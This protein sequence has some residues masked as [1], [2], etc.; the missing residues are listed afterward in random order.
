MFSPPWS[1]TPQVQIIDRIPYRVYPVRPRHLREV[2]TLGRRWGARPNVIQGEQEVSF[3]GLLRGARR[4]AHDLATHGVRQGDR[5]LLL[6]WNS[7]DWVVN[8]W[9]CHLLGAVPALANAWWS[10]AEIG[11]AIELLQPTIVLADEPG[12]R[13]LPGGVPLAPWPVDSGGEA[14]DLLSPTAGHE[15]DPAVIIFTSGTSGQPKAVELSHRALLANL[16][17]LLR[18]SHRLP[19]EV[20]DTSGEVALHTG[21]LFHVGGP[22]MLLRSVVV[23]NTFVLPAGRFEPANVLELIE[24]HRIT[25]WSAVP[26]MVTRLLDH[27]DMAH[28]DLSSLTSV[29]I[30]GAPVH[31][32]LLQRIGAELPGVRAGVPTGYGLTENGGQATA[33]SGRD[34]LQH[35]G[36][37]GRP[38]PCAE[39]SFQAREG[40]PDAEILLRAPTQMTRYIG[41]EES[42]IDANGWLHTGD[43]GH[44]DEDGRL[45][46]TGRAKDLIIRGGENIAPAAVERALYLIRGV[47]EAAVIGIPHPDLGEEVCAFVVT[48]E[49]GP[50]IE[51]IENALRSNLASFAVPTVWHVKHEPLPTNQTGKIDKAALADVA[52]SKSGRN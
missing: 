45:W 9:A 15:S 24:R 39:V 13:R 32:E 5:V 52:R 6:G 19:H 43:L 37:A 4:K 1:D 17:M 40:L 34:T 3:D 35:P 44:L 2:L 41:V 7:P 25:R 14:V 50:T 12:A 48:D 10:A 30:G 26:T 23:G 36:S 46:I 18:L 33:A 51:D 42:P 22:Q 29:T 31:A 21:P 49:A 28:R 11:G 47:T 38:L 8:F 16:Q 20:D 27:A